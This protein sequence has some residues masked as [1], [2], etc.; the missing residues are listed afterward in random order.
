MN[1]R[2][3][4]ASQ[5]LSF[6]VGESPRVRQALSDLA[7]ALDVGEVFRSRDQSE[8]PVTSLRRATYLDEL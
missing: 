1:E 2:L 6:L 5:P 3:S 7:V 8:V 4:F